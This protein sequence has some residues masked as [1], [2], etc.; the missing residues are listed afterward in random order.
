MSRKRVSKG[1]IIMRKEDKLPL[2][3][4]IMRPEFT[5]DDYLEAFKIY[6]PKDWLNINKR[7]NEH[8][9]LTKLGKTHPMPEPKK[10]LLMMSQKYINAV[11]QKHKKGWVISQNEELE[12]KNKINVYTEKQRKKLSN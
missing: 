1:Q 4:E 3:A 10:Y 7:Y 11:R 12:I 9:K 8:E 6:F 2:L 5:N